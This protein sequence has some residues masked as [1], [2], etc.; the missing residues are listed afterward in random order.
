MV[1]ML[2][3][4]YSREGQKS[5]DKCSTGEVILLYGYSHTMLVNYRGKEVNLNALSA[6]GSGQ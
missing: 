1:L 5:R 6:S 4:Y 3:S 2:H